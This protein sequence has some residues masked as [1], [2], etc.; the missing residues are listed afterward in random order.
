MTVWLTALV[1]FAVVLVVLAVVRTKLGSKF[2]IRASDI[3]VALI[4]AGLLLFATGKIQQMEFAGVKL[5]TVIKDASASKAAET[6]LPVEPVE[7][8]AKAGESE[9]PRLIAEGTEALTFVLGS[10]LYVGGV[11]GAYLDQLTQHGALRY[12]VINRPDGRF[13]GLA[14]A[15]EM[16]KRIRGRALSADEFASML[17]ASN[18]ERLKTLPGFVS[19]D[20]AVT[21]TTEKRA[22][23]RIMDDLGVETLPVVDENGKFEGVVQ[24]SRL[25]ASILVDIAGRL[26]GEQGHS[27]QQQ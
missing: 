19:A 2:E 8:H 20:Q 15:G 17:G 25:S 18:E 4:L 26:E 9:I 14:D 11:I 3:V 23:L 24:Q 27:D 6:V 12:I 13:L 10:D 1:L 22:A 21:R 7:V 16:A 5:A